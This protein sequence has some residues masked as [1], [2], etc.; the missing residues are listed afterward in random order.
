M[1]NHGSAQTT[2]ISADYQSM[3]GY[4]WQGGN[5]YISNGVTVEATYA[6][7]AGVSAVS[8]ML[9]TLTNDGGTLI[10]GDAG[11]GN[12]AG[13]SIDVVNNNGVMRG[14]NVGVANSGYL[15]TLNNSGRI[16][17]GYAGI[18]ST[19]SIGV[20]NN[21]GVMDGIG[22]GIVSSG[23]IGTINNSGS[24][25][26]VIGVE[27]LSGTIGT[28]NNSGLIRSSFL[29]ISVERAGGLQSL[30]NSGTIA[31]NISYSPTS[32]LA[33]SG[34]TGTSFGILTGSSGNLGASDIGRLVAAGNVRF[35]SGNQLLNDH[36]DV[37]SNR[38]I[39]DAANLQINH[40]ITITGDYEQRADAALIIGV[41]NDAQGTG[42]VAGDSG[43]GKLLVNGHATLESG[44]TVSL[45]RLDSYAFAA[46]QRFVVIQAD[47]ADYHADSLQYGAS[48]FNG[49]VR[50]ANVHTN[51]KDALVLTLGNGGDGG[52]GDGGLRNAADNR[53]AW[54]V[55]DALYRYDGI[56][57][58]VLRLFNPA[59]ALDSAAT[60][61]RAG[62]QLTPVAVT[63]A[64]S[65]A[66]RSTFQGVF[67][68]T[69][70][71]IDQRR[72][73]AGVSGI[74]SG[75]AARQ[76][77]IWSKAFGGRISQSEHD[78]SAGYHGNFRGM[79]IGADTLVTNDWRAGAV[80]SYAST[81]MANDGSN[82]GS[83]VKVNSY[84]VNAYASYDAHPAYLNMMMGA[85]RQQF[86]TVRTVD[87]S[88]FTEQPAG[89][90]NGMQYLASLQAGYPL[91]M[92]SGIRLTPLA[93]LSYSS[94]RQ[95]GYT[96]RGSAAALA[97]QAAASS[98]LKSDLGFRLERTLAT[99]LGAVTPS[100]QLGWRHE[101]HDSRLRSDSSFVADAS[102]VTDFVTTG[103]A[104][105]KDTAVL[106]LGVMLARSRN[107]SIAAN[108]A[109]EAARGYTV[110]SAEM[111]L[112]WQY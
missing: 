18:K 23:S 47:S 56:N 52:N 102:N 80:L 13:A 94:L 111:R 48:G 27:A 42:N 60:A 76:S 99:S 84:G 66:A 63:A 9:G 36:I 55:L 70:D 78:E 112:R 34:G 95:D 57:S 105:I 97:I 58:D 20:I 8:G 100:L 29:A 53:H 7:A 74:A 2:T 110:Q 98:S 45:A 79:L 68:A 61:N 71:H 35:V 86:R 81:S 40:L 24:I 41:D 67:K 54:T 37:G 83:S 22:R 3:S 6:L 103:V 31:G 43:Y 21:A 91:E 51:G 72:S 12:F 46:G 38:V 93:G 14:G 65:Q 39:N 5:L 87:F 82:T 11:L 49:V 96:E 32:E 26:G 88:G 77:A 28:L 16:N 50:G 104:P 62:A 33:I 109:V 10:G 25:Y 92:V 59:L 19:G 30:I 44:S 108:Y 85:A 73:S 1:P 4:R 90:F 17:G 89:S 101:F 107:L 75:E 69:A 15:G 64:S 106:G